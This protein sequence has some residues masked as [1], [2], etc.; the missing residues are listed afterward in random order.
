MSLVK[1]SKLICQSM[2]PLICNCA[3]S[4]SPTYSNSTYTNSTFTMDSYSRYYDDED[5]GSNVMVLD[6]PEVVIQTAKQSTNPTKPKQKLEFSLK[7]S[8]KTKSRPRVEF[9]PIIEKGKMLEEAERTARTPSPPRPTNS[10]Q[11]MG[12]THSK[13]Q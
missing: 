6:S 4:L 3:F 12:L 8:K 1:Q 10:K 9:S 11:G 5:T 13:S 7:W 2:K